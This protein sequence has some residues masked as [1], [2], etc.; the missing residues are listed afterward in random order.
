MSKQTKEKKVPYIKGTNKLSFDEDQIVTLASK[1]W[2]ISEI[3][4]FYGVDVTTI[5]R[6]FPDL[7]TKGREK[8]KGR[9]RDAQLKLALGGNATMLIWLGKQYLGQKDAET[10]DVLS[11]PEIK[12]NVIGNESTT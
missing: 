7:L 2:M 1:F 4:A 11:M 3:A 10:V 6:R 12:I 9:L 8:G 5:S